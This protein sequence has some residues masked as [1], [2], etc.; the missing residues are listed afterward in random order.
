MLLYRFSALKS[1]FRRTIHLIIAIQRSGIERFFDYSSSAFLILFFKLFPRSFI[2]HKIFRTDFPGHIIMTDDLILI[3][4][5]F[6]YT[7]ML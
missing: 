3:Q 4:I 1:F 5:I 6:F 2:F 7:A